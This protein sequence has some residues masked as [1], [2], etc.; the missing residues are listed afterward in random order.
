MV[1]LIWLYNRFI[2]CLTQRING[3][4]K[5]DYDEK[6]HTPGLPHDQSHHDRWH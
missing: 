1:A 4:I 6:R 3:H 2:F 5:D